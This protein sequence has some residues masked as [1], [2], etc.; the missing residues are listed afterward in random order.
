M[1]MLK[2]TGVLLTILFII[3]CSDHSKSLS[4]YI[5]GEYTYISTNVAGTLTQLAVQRG[6]QVVKGDALF[7]LDPQ[8]E[9][10]TVNA[11]KATLKQDQAEVDLAKIQLQRQQILYTK[12]ASDKS[13][14][15]EAQTDYQSKWEILQ[16]AE[17]NLYQAQWALNQKTVSAPVDGLVFDTFYRLGE[18]VPVTN[19]VLALLAPNNIRVIFFVPEGMLSKIKV[20]QTIKF[21]CDSCKQETEATINYISPQAEYTP[22]IIYSKDTRDKLV[23]LIRAQMPRD[24]AKKFHPGQPI[25]VSLPNQDP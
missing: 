13:N 4:G 21:S 19:P 10:D 1:S 14:V 6:Q 20:G 24:T 16:A 9:S 18:K 3:S 2:K 5:E 15:D 7:T 8:P 25:D 22:P 12:N 17:A 23:Y 11:A